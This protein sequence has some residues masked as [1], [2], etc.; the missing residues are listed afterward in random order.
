[1]HERWRP[2]WWAVAVAVVVTFV[3]GAATYTPLF[4]ADDIR[5][6][7]ASIPDAEVLAIAGLDDTTNVFHLDE[8]LIEARLRAD[9]RILDA[10]VRT[11]LPD[12]ISIAVVPRSAVAILDSSLVG[13]DGVVIGPV[14]PGL[15]SLPSIRGNVRAGAATAAAMSPGLRRSVDAIVVA[16]DGEI[17]VRLGPASSAILGDRTQLSAK[18]ASLAA[19]LRW[20]AG[21]GVSIASADV[22]VPGSPSVKLDDGRSVTPST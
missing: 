3:G 15:G 2:R 9:P 14:V 5:V 19:L 8:E 10:T 6:E 20:A 13:E 22:T 4:A 16:A 12:A 17:R 7:G 18:T 11:S 21:A 1:M